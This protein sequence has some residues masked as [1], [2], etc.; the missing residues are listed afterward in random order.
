MQA[1]AL[2][3]WVRDDLARLAKVG[4]VPT[5]AEV[6]WLAELAKAAHTPPGREQIQTLAA[7]VKFCG[8]VFYPAHLLARYWVAEWMDVFEGDKLIQDGIYLLAHVHSKPGD[9]RLT[10]LTNADEVAEVVKAWLRKQEF[11]ECDMERIAAALY[12]MDHG[13]SDPIPHPDEVKEESKHYV[14][15]EERVAGLCDLFPCTTPLFWQSEISGI[16]AERLASAMIA[17]TGDSGAWA[18]SSLRTRRIA[19]YMNAVKWITQRSLKANA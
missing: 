1:P 17:Q 15:L 14:T 10:E 9:R 8:A 5:L 6:V 13:E 18:N 4:I 19:S 12:R 2:H 16:E 7:P 3:S 11:G